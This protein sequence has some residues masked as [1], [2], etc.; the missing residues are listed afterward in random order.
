MFAQIK[1]QDA[2]KAAVGQ[3]RVAMAKT[4]ENFKK[5]HGMLAW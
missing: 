1:E 5:A 3:V 4:Y 2:Y